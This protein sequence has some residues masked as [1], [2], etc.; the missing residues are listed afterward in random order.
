MGTVT[1]GL[2]GTRAALDEDDTD[3]RQSRAGKRPPSTYGLSKQARNFW[4][5]ARRPPGKGLPLGL[6]YC[7][8]SQRSR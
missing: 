2:P 6:S 7:V 1:S 8:D 3:C 4:Q 5:E